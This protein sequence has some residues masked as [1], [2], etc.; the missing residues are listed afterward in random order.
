VIPAAARWTAGRWFGT[1]AATVS[2]ATRGGF[3]GLPGPV[4][5]LLG[6]GAAGLL[7][8]IRVRRHHSKPILRVG[9]AV[10]EGTAA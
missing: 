5:V 2:A 3:G 4:L 7:A 1:H 9:G 6:A 8:T 10:P